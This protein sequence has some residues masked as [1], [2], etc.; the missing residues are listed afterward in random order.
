[1]T[2]FIRKLQRVGSSILV[3]L[4]KEW[5]SSNNLQKGNEVQVEMNRDTLTVTTIHSH[6]QTRD[7][8]ITYPLPP[9][10]NISANLTGAYL[11]GYDIICITSK[12]AIPTKDREDIRNSSRRLV[13]LEIVE[14]GPADITMQFLLDPTTLNAQRILYRMNS[15]SLGM[16]GEILKGMRTGDL[17]ALGTLQN[18]DVE[19]NRQYFLLVRLIRRAVVDGRLSESFDLKVDVLDY[20]VAANL[21]ENAG[22]LIVR[23]GDMLYNS[24]IDDEQLRHV[25]GIARDLEGLATK[26]VE[27]LIHHDR[28]LAISAISLHNQYQSDLTKLRMGVSGD[29]AMEYIELI[30]GFERLGQFWSDVADLVRPI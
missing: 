6:R 17:S 24:S 16:F 29:V 19:V 21:L 15:I 7:M 13:G 26:A 20:R 25:H 5:I 28:H 1:M 10:E 3:S 14:E 18:R 9:D 27:A 11:F 2:K 23:L 12:S 4:P 30:Y 22:D 8:V